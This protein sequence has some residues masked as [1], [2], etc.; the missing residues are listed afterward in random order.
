MTHLDLPEALLAAGWPWDCLP[1]ESQEAHHLQ[2]AIE[3]LHREALREGAP[4]PP[5]E[6]E[7]ERS[8]PLAEY[9]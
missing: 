3:R 4:L 1:G 8:S 6:E 7:E 5:E 9:W 2:Q